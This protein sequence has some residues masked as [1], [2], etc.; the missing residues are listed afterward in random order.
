MGI[1]AHCDK[2]VRHT[3]PRPRIAIYTLV[4]T[5]SLVWLLQWITITVCAFWSAVNLSVEKQA[6]CLQE[7]ESEFS[8]NGVIV[9]GGTGNIGNVDASVTDGACAASLW[10]GQGF[11]G[12]ALG[13]YWD[14]QRIDATLTVLGL[15]Y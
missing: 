4:T 9:D 12:A 13:C 14:G 6:K 5:M 15:L 3:W 7:V 1:T 11:L 8:S 2:T 10:L